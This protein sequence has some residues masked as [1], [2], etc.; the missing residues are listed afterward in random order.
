[1]PSG[2]DASKEAIAAGEAAAL[3]A[4][5]TPAADPHRLTN[6]G[7]TEADRDRKRR[8]GKLAKE[9]IVWSF[10]REGVS[11]MLTTPTAIVIARLLSPYDFGI[12]ASASFFLSL[13]TRLTNFGFNQALVRVKHLRPEHNS[14]VFA[15]SLVIGILA[16]T[17]LSLTA[18]L[19]AAFFRA[20]EL[21]QVMPWAALTFIISPV[22]TVPAALLSRNMEFKRTAACDWIGGIGEAGTAI[23]LSF[24]GFGYWSL[25]YSRIVSDILNTTAK[26][27]LGRWRPSLRFSMEATRELFSFGAGV[28]AKR[29]LDYSAKNLDNLVVGRVLGIT[30]LGFYDKAFMTMN[31]VLTRIN[32][33]GPMVSFRVFSIIY[34]EPERFR[35]AYR[36]VVL[37]SSLV[38]YPLLVGLAAAAHELII[39]MYGPRWSRAIVPFQILCVAGA[40]KVLNEYAGSAAQA[41]GKI[42]GQVWRQVIYSGLIVVCVALL[43]PWGLPGAALGVLIATLGMVVLMNGMLMRIAS[44]PLGDVVGPQVPGLLGAIVTGGSI[45]LVRWLVLRAA[46]PAKIELLALEALTGGLAYAAFIKFNRFREVR[47]LVRDVATDLAPPFSRV[48]RLLV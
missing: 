37:A 6:P 42:W 20:P 11:E 43:S 28:F 33:G 8:Y 45:L 24:M 1:M 38:S 26:V 25:V 14:S 36:R 46:S 19:M 31:K 18:P 23:T 4:E 27:L 3:A 5:K 7:A 22:G 44:L 47:I 48:V 16:Y 15:V 17:T 39:V 13:A 10:F 32:T 30:T 29:L 21:A 2:T 34:E 40:L 9:G 41:W 12:A 35:K